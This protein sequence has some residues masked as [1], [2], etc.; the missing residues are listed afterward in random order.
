MG[1]ACPPGEADLVFP[2]RDGTVERYVNLLGVLE[3]VEHTTANRN[4]PSLPSATSS[5]R[6]RGLSTKMVQHLLGHSSIVMTLDTYPHLLPSDGDRTELAAA[7][8]ALL[9]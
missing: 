3:T 5:P 2:N 6:G 9:G 7:S 8:A 1:H 4:T